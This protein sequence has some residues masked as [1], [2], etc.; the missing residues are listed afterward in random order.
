MDN[1]YKASDYIKNYFQSKVL[2]DY[3]MN[4][5]KE[6]LLLKRTDSKAMLE[7][8]NLLGRH[9][10][11]SFVEPDIVCGDEWVPSLMLQYLW[12][13]KNADVPVRVSIFRDQVQYVEIVDMFNVAKHFGE[14]FDFVDEFKKT[15]ELVVALSPQK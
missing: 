13:V 10:V 5:W 3:S 6:T 7:K 8:W 4:K 2:C 1:L 12:R 14:D 11:P 15:V 9:F